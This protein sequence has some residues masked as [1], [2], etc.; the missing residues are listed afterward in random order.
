MSETG[1]YYAAEMSGEAF[2]PKLRA[3]Y[4]ALA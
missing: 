4:G 1:S 2:Y 3:T